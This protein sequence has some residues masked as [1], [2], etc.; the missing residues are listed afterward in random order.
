[1]KY[2]IFIFCIKLNLFLFSHELLKP[3]V[4]FKYGRWGW[5]LQEAFTLGT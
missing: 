4:L 1:M 2:L 5:D 3:L